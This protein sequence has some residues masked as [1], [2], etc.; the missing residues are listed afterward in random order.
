MIEE[1]KTNDAQCADI[2]LSSKASLL[3]GSD[4]TNATGVSAEYMGAG[5][6]ATTASSPSPTAST[7]GNTA[8]G[9]S[10]GYLSAILAGTTLAIFGLLL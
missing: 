9:T 6:A 7:K 4:C 8:A 3:A 2:T 5:S 1:D 10:A